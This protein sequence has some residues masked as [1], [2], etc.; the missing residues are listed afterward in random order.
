LWKVFSDHSRKHFN[1]TIEVS[2]DYFVKETTVAP[3]RPTIHTGNQ[4]SLFVYDGLQD[5]MFSSFDRGFVLHDQRNFI[6][7]IIMGKD[8]YY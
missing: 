4:Q 1:P 6:F 8:C 3:K 7:L 2:H 5:Y